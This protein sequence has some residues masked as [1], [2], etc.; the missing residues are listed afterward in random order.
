VVLGLGDLAM[1]HVEH[2]DWRIRAPA[3]PQQFVIYTGNK[4]LAV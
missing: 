4:Y 2:G 1:F 3:L